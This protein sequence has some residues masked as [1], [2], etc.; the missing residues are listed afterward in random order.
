M[1]RLCTLALGPRATR[2]ALSLAACLLAIG[3]AGCSS[4]NPAFVNLLG[5]NLSNSL[6]TISNAP[7]HVVVALINNAEIDEKLVSFLAGDLGLTA[8]DAAKLHPRVR[9]RIRITFVDGTF[10]TV[11]MI[12]GSR[13]FVQPAFNAEAAPD[14]NQNDLTNVVAQCDVAQVGLEPGSNIEIF[15]PVE[16]QEF[17]LTEN[18]DNSGATIREFIL[19][20]TRPPQFT[21]LAVDLVDGDQNIILRRNIDVRDQLPTTTNIV[22]GSVIA[23]NLNGVLA[24]PFQISVAENGAPSFDRDDV[25]TVGAIGGRYEFRVTV[26]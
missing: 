8:A 7:G 23:I 21:P 16:L 14:L 17:E 18:A 15:I 13:T 12:S 5:G 24:V 11:E 20:Q 6:A 19:R 3:T 9:M 26:R 25:Q 4:L 1:V 22:C 2:P 10:Q